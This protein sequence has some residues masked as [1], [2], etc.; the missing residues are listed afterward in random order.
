M[1]RV[2][3]IGNVELLDELVKKLHEEVPE[4]YYTI[5]PV[6]KGY[7][8]KGYASG[9]LVWPE[10]NFYCFL[11]LKEYQDYSCLKTMCDDIQKGSPQNS[12]TIFVYRIESLIP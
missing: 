12:L 11:H 6:E 5:L 3:I 9:D 1:I 8:K 10:S 2:E 7:G 4:Y